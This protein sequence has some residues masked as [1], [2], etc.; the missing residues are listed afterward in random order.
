MATTVSERRASA[1]A[2]LLL[3]LSCLSS[4]AVLG[5]SQLVPG[6]R[7][8]YAELDEKLETDIL[9]ALCAEEGVGESES[10]SGKR[11]VPLFCSAM[12]GKNTNY[13]KVTSEA[14]LRVTL[15]D[16]TRKQWYPKN[17]VVEKGCRFPQREPKENPEFCTLDDLV[18]IPTGSF[19]RQRKWRNDPRA[20]HGA[21]L[22]FIGGIF[23]ESDLGNE[24]FTPGLS[25]TTESCSG[26]CKAGYQCMPSLELALASQ[27]TL[28]RCEPCEKGS[29]CPSGTLHDGGLALGSARLNLCP[30]G[31]FCPNTT[32]AYECPSG[33]F[34]PLGSHQPF[35]CSNISMSGISIEGNYCP[36][37]SSTPL[38]F[39]PA[40]WYCPTASIA[41]ACPEGHYCE[42][43]SK[44]PKE[45]GM[46]SSCPVGTA[47][48]GISLYLVIGLG[49]LFGCFLL[50][51]LV[52]TVWIKVSQRSVLRRARKA[53]KQS[54]LLKAIGVK[55]GL[56]SDQM[57]YA[58]NLKGFSENIRLVDIVVDNLSVEVKSH[59]K[60]K[61][62]LRG[63]NLLFRASTLNVILGSS[64]A[65]K[66]TF[67]KS[68]VGKFSVNSQPRGEI[69]FEFKNHPIKVNL[70][71]STGGRSG[72]CGGGSMCKSLTKLRARETAVQLGVG[73]VAQDNVVHEILTVNENI[74][75]SARMRLGPSLSAQTK[76]EIIQDTI[77]VLGLNHI[78][79]AKVGNPLSPAGS[80]SGGEARR[81]SIGLELVA[82]PSL[83]ILDEPTS[84]LDAVAAND[85][86]SSL[87]K[88]SDLGVT[89]VASLHQ[90]RY[91]TFLLFDALHLFMRG[92]YVV[93][94]GPT[95][96]ALDYFRDIGFKLHENE[97]PADFMLDVIA[98]LI[99]LPGHE[100]FSPMDLVA[101]WNDEVRAD[102]R[103]RRSSFCDSKG[104]DFEDVAL[105]TGRSK[106]DSMI[107]SRSQSFRNFSGRDFDL[108][109]KACEH[110]DLEG[111]KESS[112]VKR[113]QSV[114]PTP[115]WLGT[116]GEQFDQLD[117]QQDG[118]IDSTT[119]LEFLQS[120][121]Q[122]CTLEEA[123]QIVRHFDVDGDGRI[124]RKDFLMRW[125]KNYWTREFSTALLGLF[126]HKEGVC[127]D[128]EGLECSIEMNN[129]ASRMRSSGS[130]KSLLGSFDANSHLKQMLTARRQRKFAFRSTAGFPKQCLYLL[131]R[132]PLKMMRTL[133]LK[134]L[135]F[136]SMAVIGVSY[137]FVNRS[138]LGS[139]LEAVKQ[140]NTV[141]MMFVGVLS[142][143]WATLFISR[144]LPMVQREVS[145][146]V[147]AGAIF[148]TLNIYNT[149]VDILVRC[150]AYTLPFFYISG[151]NQTLADFLLIAFGTAW[152]CS[153][154][155]MIMPCVTN[156]R[157]AVVLSVAI[158]FLFGA[159]LN[160]VRPSIKELQDASNPLLYWMVLPSYNRWATEALT[161]QEEA[162]N[163]DYS[164]A[165]KLELN[166]F[167]YDPSNW[168]TAVLFLYLS[169]ILLRLI[170]FF[171]F[172]KKALE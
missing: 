21:D 168:L 78:Q 59:G 48:Q 101:L 121:G 79:N 72:C 128:E 55:L 60:S 123:N 5:R 28:G 127:V 87:N 130:Q 36:P 84:G 20:A 96:G 16:D 108:G 152:S 169:G 29:L 131:Q 95:S 68:L 133:E 150:L 115:R 76:K 113:T 148:A 67:L 158:T 14:T 65:G 62:V 80:I 22:S 27:G 2:V 165:E 33:Y 4:L 98:G 153:G 161:I 163:T 7:V 164:F 99:D 140:A 6:D 26:R 1:A 8:T 104:M 129:L 24:D 82:C 90:P 119:M 109:V 144:E 44:E 38:N 142:S 47:K 53:E 46:L 141:G 124:M 23:A 71:S 134:I 157:S 97:N 172:Y 61:L 57:S 162:A 112:R 50:L 40:G 145:E 136:G 102:D 35:S 66:T 74:A 75:Y 89:V 39:C 42:V 70:L 86:M 17:W 25:M 116:L 10:E 52:L 147:H 12:G 146:G 32:T 54:T 30:V 18:V 156:P 137:A 105:D 139:N 138:V 160:G 117:A 92:G 34:C 73:Y 110:V 135:D 64:G 77:T 122:Q 103:F 45:C 49:A 85:V 83:L 151:Y 106:D 118:Y 19:Q 166:S 132:E 56:G 9:N 100:R 159:V 63:V 37:A 149:A 125:T 31:Y 111:G 41:V 3:L 107:S 171:F 15:P 126:P 154:L 155:G 11:V 143:L 94:S 120:M 69:R 170:C 167:G 43:Q 13:S 93:Y 91:S 51:L 88:M 58:S 114:V 81:V